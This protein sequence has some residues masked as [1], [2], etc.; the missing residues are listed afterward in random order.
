MIRTYLR[1]DLRDGASADFVDLFR[2][3][4]ILETSLA[5][6]GCLSAELT[7]SETGG[8]A[9]VTATWT[10]R[11]AYEAWTNRADRG[12][13]AERLNACLTTPLTAATIGE[14]HTVAHAPGHQDESG[15]HIVEARET[16]T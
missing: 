2:D 12:A 14:V 11:H 3:A 16:D 15:N 4:A 7:V 9:T 10:D 6:P 1:F 8:V 13:Y 5:Q